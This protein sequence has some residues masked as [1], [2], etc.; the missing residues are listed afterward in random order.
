[1]DINENICKMMGNTQNFAPQK[2][3][4]FLDSNLAVPPNL[5]LEN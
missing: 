4:S 2:S 1:M 5:V 3:F